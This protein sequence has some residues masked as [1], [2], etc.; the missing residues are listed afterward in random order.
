MV[1]IAAFCYLQPSLE[2]T[3]MESNEVPSNSSA[4]SEVAVNVPLQSVDKKEE[5][6]GEKVSRRGRRTHT[7]THTYTHTHTHTHTQHC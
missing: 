6:P 7:H 3:P 1:L 5:A 2:E 4:R